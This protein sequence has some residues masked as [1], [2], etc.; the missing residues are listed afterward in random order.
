[1]IS[2]IQTSFVVKSGEVVP[3]T[4]IIATI[5]HKLAHTDTGRV[6]GYYLLDTRGTNE[7][8]GQ[9]STRWLS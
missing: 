9:V 1:M 5:S 3:K 8:R 2:I 7:P 6:S 4:Y